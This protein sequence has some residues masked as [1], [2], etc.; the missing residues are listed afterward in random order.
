MNTFGM[1]PTF[2]SST[3]QRRLER[4]SLVLNFEYQP[5]SLDKW[6]SLTILAR[7]LHVSPQNGSRFF[8]LVAFLKRVLMSWT[9]VGSLNLYMPP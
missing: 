5:K 4:F 7:E 3:V 8:L 1:Q 9:G 6:K 2:T